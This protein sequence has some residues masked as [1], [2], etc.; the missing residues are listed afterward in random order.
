MSKKLKLWS[1]DAEKKQASQYNQ[2]MKKATKDLCAALDTHAADLGKT[3]SQQFATSKQPKEEEVKKKLA[4]VTALL[5][6]VTKH[7]GLLSKL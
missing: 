6:D 4:R 3:Y 5:S 7:Q 1:I 2:K